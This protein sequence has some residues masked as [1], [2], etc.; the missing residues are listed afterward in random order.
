MRLAQLL[1]M[2]RFK[3]DLTVRQLAEQLGV[4][5]S[6]LSRIESGKFPDYTSM[7]KLINWIFSLKG[8]S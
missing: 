4:S 7:L 5:T 8:D 1:K 6:T 3:Y 2:Y